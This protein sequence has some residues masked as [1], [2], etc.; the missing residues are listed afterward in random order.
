MAT[1]DVQGR[2]RR[3]NSEKGELRGT[4]EGLKS[5]TAYFGKCISVFSSTY[6]AFL[7]RPVS[8]RTKHN[9]MLK[10]NIM[11]IHALPRK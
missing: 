6:Y 4:N 5:G 10:G 11:T 2:I 7:I 1:E 8:Q 3:T 9:V